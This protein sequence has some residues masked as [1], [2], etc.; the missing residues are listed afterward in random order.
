MTTTEPIDGQDPRI[1]TLARRLIADAYCIP[2]DELDDDWPS[3]EQAQTITGVTGRGH[4][5]Q[6]VR[7]SF[8]QAAREH[9]AAVDAV[10]GGTSASS[11]GATP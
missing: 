5:R 1:D 11:E 8:T 7:D 2:L 6:G 4:I 3:P 10:A 9:L